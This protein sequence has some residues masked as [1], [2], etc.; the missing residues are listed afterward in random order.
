MTRAGLR[1]LTRDF[2]I[3]FATA[4]DFWQLPEAAAYGELAAR[5][6][7]LL[8]PENQLKWDAVH[9]ECDRYD[10]APAERHLDFA[11][12]H[13]M[14]VHGHTLVWH[15]ANPAW[16]T[17]QRDVPPAMAEA[18]DAH[19][20]RVVG[21]FR[22]RIAIWDVANEAFEEDGSFRE[23][24][25]L[26]ALGPGYLERSFVRARAADPEA[27]LLYNDYNIE[28]VCP[29]SNATYELLRELRGRGVPVD[30]VGFQM[31][32]TIEE[33][34]DL[35]SF[36][37]NMARF[38]A[39]GLRIYLTEMDVRLRVPSTEQQ[40]EEQARLYG[41]VMERC[42][43]EPACRAVQFWGLSDRYSWVPGFFGVFDAA[44]PFDASG[45]PKPAYAAV[46]D[47]LASSDR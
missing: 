13:G 35:D 4:N 28:V 9:P 2:G 32:R 15:Q 34:L 16:L 43:R 26:G 33:A 14:T 1:S 20:A 38:A 37:A 11:A 36:S 40:L 47:A 41:A 45:R 24:L 42:L 8:T 21:H 23:T 27:V 6:F 29:K 31:H 10:F 22:S 19:I 30:G 5:E 25:W 12:R 18:L 3:G 39:L 7:N 44:L 17:E 46:H